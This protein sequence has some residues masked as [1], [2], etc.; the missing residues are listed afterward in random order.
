MKSIFPQNGIVTLPDR[1]TIGRVAD[2]SITG[3]I[4]SVRVA[5]LVVPLLFSLP[6][7][8]RAET[9]VESVDYEIVEEAGP[10][11]VNSKAIARFGPFA[12]INATTAELNGETDTRA[13]AQFAQMIAA[14][15]MLQKI[16]M[17]ECA[18]TVDDEAN[19]KVARMIRRAGLSTHVPA[20]GSVR[21]GGV[22]LFMAGVRRTHEKGAEFG[23]HSWEDEDGHQARDVPAD[24]PVNAAYLRYYQDVGLPAETARAFYAFTN[25]TPF[26]QLHVMSESE[27]QQFHV[28]N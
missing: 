18:G 5:F 9:I 16:N 14:F 13:P 7:M 2:L 17:I 11:P 15:P 26:D 28:T 27:L 19:L 21:S 10:P 6:Q 3:L 4:E 25:A 1:R 20:N 8:A 23:V 12:V 22:E 24:D